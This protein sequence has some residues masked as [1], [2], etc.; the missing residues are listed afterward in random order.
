MRYIR[1]IFWWIFFMAPAEFI[2][3]AL[4]KG[5]IVFFLMAV[6]FYSFLLTI[7]YIFGRKRWEKPESQDS[8]LVWSFIIGISCLLII[9][10]QLTGNSPTAN[11]DATQ[12]SMFIWW[13][14]VFLFPKVMILEK[15]RFLR[16]KVLMY[17]IFYSIAFIA[18]IPVF[19]N[20]LAFVFVYAYGLWIF[21]YFL[22][23]YVRFDEVTIT[24]K[25][26]SHP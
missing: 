22:Y 10:W 24:E 15:Y 9:E 6:G 3:N 26:L 17:Q 13:I 20:P 25:S 16:K 4:I 7:A 11:P 2:I 21:Y 18:V 5:N 23:L 8:K 1:Y 19:G 12:S 14:W